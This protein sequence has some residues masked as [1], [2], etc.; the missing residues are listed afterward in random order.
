[1]N[2]EHLLETARKTFYTEFLD[3]LSSLCVIIIYFSK[4]KKKGSKLLAII[5]IAGF[6]QLLVYHYSMLFLGVSARKHTLHSSIYIYLVIEAACCLMYLKAQIKSTWVKKTILF[7]MILYIGYLILVACSLPVHFAHY[8]EIFEGFLITIFCLYYFY[9][10]FTQRIARKLSTEPAF[11]AILGML[12]LFCMTMPLWGLL[13]F[14]VKGNSM[15]KESL[16][17]INYL[18]YTFFFI[19]LS[20]AILCDKSITPPSMQ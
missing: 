7:S 15:L 14:F 18:A 19:A 12:I 9:E 16:F 1:M 8:V 5:A 17:T 4:G 20:K 3:E 11:W 13:N 2:W 6:L 10:S